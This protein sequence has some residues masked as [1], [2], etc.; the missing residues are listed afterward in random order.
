MTRAYQ[1]LTLLVAAA[2]FVFQQRAQLTGESR[3]ELGFS[4]AAVGRF[5]RDF[6]VRG[7]ANHVK[8]AQGVMH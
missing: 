7:A 2:I 1:A 5:L 3:H 8:L 6:H 4:S